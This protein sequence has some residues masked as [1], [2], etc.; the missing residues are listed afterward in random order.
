MAYKRYTTKK[1]DKELSKIKNTEDRKHIGKVMSRLEEDPYNWDGSGEGEW[2]GSY[3]KYVGKKGY[4]IVYAF[5]E[6]CEKNEHQELVHCDKC[7]EIPKDSLVFR[8]IFQREE[9][10]GN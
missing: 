4:R 3:Y 10:Y 1:F 8:R 9:G 5:C 7:C 2:K 6:L